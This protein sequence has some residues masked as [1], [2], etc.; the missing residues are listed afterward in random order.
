MSYFFQQVIDLSTVYNSNNQTQR[1]KVIGPH[2]AKVIH[3]LYVYNRK[4]KH[5]DV[6]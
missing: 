5:S 3:Y 4:N 6:L 1:A 2:G